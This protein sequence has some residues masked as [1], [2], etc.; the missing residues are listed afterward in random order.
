MNIILGS[1]L[2]ACIAKRLLGQD[3]SFIPFKKSRYYSFDIPLAD[4]FIRCDKD[5]DIVSAELGLSGPIIIY[6]RLFSYHG[7]LTNSTEPVVI[8]PYIKK[9]YD[10]TRII[11]DSL[12]KTTFSV[13]NIRAIT[14]YSKLNEQFWNQIQVGAQKK[15][16]SIDLKARTLCL[17]DGSTINYERM[18]STIPLNALYKFCGINAPTLKAKA[19]CSYRIQSNKIDLEGAEQT[20]VSDLDI[21]FYKVTK[22]SD[23]Y[24]FNTFEAIENP[25]LYFGKFLGYQLDIVEVLRVD[26]VIPIGEVPDLTIFE[27]AGITCVG[28]NAQHDDF[29]DL[30]S[31]IKRL[32]NFK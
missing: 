25:Y 14:L 12:L 9:V 21:E 32:V 2:I 8:D 17:S 24:I 3:W 29:M 13:Y 5:I 26:E 31:S 22:W 19:V 10:N 11:V 6:K 4:D 18:I 20:L 15:L 30:G 16:V 7:Q 28:S 23:S 27:N 1:G